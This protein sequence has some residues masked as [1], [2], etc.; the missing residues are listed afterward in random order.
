MT[1]AD[2]ARRFFFLLLA[3]ATV[4]FALVVRPLASALF[5]AA[6][7]AGV[8]APL[9][10][11]L[12][13]CLGRRARLAALAEGLDAVLVC[14]ENRSGSGVGWLTGWPVTAEAVAL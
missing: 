12:S 1:S 8:L 4:L 5:L 10:R 2:S 7:L 14:G 9:H 3:A 13:A 6:A 11:R